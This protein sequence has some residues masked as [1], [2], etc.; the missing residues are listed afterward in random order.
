MYI[1]DIIHR[2]SQSLVL[3]IVQGM[4]ILSPSLAN[5]QILC[6]NYT[7]QVSERKRVAMDNR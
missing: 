7:V 6:I 4:D 5:L 3:S 1:R 2:D